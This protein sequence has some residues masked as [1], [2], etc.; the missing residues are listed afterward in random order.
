MSTPVSQPVTPVQP[1]QEVYGIQELGLFSTYTRDSYRALF[2]IEAPAWDPSRVTKTWFDSTVDTSNP[3]NIAIYQTITLNQ[4]AQWT[5]SPLVLP[6]QEAAIV[7]LPG[8]AVYPAYVVMPTSATRGGSVINPLYL[9]MELDAR[10]IMAEFGAT[11]L[12]DEGATAQFPV[13]YP[14]DEPR[15]MWG[16]VF[17]GGAVNVGALQASSNANGIGAPGQWNTSGSEPV[18]VPAPAAP[19]GLNDTRPARPMPVR[20]LLANEKIQPGLMG[21]SIVRTDLQ[22]Q[23]NAAAG[24]FTPDDRA[25]LQQIF[26]IVSKLGL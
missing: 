9:S 23:A 6:A 8:A 3:A 15:R 5:M 7:N 20:N 12:S 13:L 25:T 22:Q 17:K 16:I 14:P 4:S 19:S 21:V 11:D 2:G 24:Q 1:N 10:A 18:W 26:K